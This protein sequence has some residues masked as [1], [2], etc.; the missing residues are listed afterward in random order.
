MEKINRI[1]KP[2][3]LI[4][5]PVFEQKLSEKELDGFILIEANNGYTPIALEESI[6]CN[7]DIST[8]DVASVVPFMINNVD[9][10]VL[11]WM[12]ETVIYSAVKD[13]C[14]QE[15]KEIEYV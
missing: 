9:R 10:V 5:T 11:H 1:L 4:V 7:V 6:R 3:T 2:R 8:E 12:T 14:K 13:H 15:G